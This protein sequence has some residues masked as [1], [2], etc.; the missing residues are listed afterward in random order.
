M[1][2]VLR[3][4]LGTGRSTSSSGAPGRETCTA[5]MVGMGL[6]FE[7]GGWWMEML[8]AGKRPV[9]RTPVSEV[10]R[11]PGSLGATDAIPVFA[12]TLR[13]GRPEL[14]RTRHDVFPVA[15]PPDAVLAIVTDLRS[16]LSIAAL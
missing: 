9:A 7:R 10:L 14:L 16:R 13:R 2:T 12:S 4:G 6:S 3:C 8:G 15:T 5:R 11:R 1:R